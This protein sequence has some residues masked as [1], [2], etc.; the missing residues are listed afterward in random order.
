[1]AMRASAAMYT[2]RLIKI[3]LRFVPGEPRS[4]MVTF[5]YVRV[6]GSYRIV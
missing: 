3:L 4:A 6:G 5:T 2:I 1:M